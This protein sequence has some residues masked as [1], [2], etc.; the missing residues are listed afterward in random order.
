MRYGRVLCALALVLASLPALC[1]AEGKVELVWIRLLSGEAEPAVWRAGEAYPE[2]KAESAIAPSALL[3]YSPLKPG[4]ALSET[5]LAAKAELWE[6]SLAESGRFSKASVFVVESE[7]DPGKRG[8]IVEAEP[9][10]SPLFGGGAAYASMALPLL[11]GRRASL[12]MAAGANTASLAYRD[13][14]FRELPLVL[15]ASA[16]YDNDL[17]ESGSF[18]GNRLSGD[19]GIGPRLG[20]LCSLVAGIRGCLPFDEVQGSSPYLAL[21]ARLEYSRPMLFGLPWLGLAFSSIATDYPLS[22]ALRLA[23]RS[24]LSA[25]LGASEL[26]C[27]SGLGLSTGS[28]DLRER[29]DLERGGFALKGP[30]GSSE[31]ARRIGLGRFDWCAPLFSL[32]LATWLTVSLGPFAFGEIAFVDDDTQARAAAGTGL[33]LMLGAPINLGLD[34]GYAFDQGGAGGIV[35]DLSSASFLL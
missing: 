8:V 12:A 22:G 31:T 34:L 7:G 13:D 18:S 16:S 24:R 2:R 29:F 21:D 1:A 11:G 27:D 26:S 15:E 6:R 17:I 28:L 10:D 33:R 5:E 3:S 23:A 32:P 4:D 35:F 19:F 9:L 30:A 25:K 20:P 14:A